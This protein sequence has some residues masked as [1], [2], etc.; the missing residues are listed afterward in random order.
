M[1]YRQ[2]GDNALYATPGRGETGAPP[3]G[4]QRQ[5]DMPAVA[6]VGAA[7]PRA[8]PAS[9]RPIERGAKDPALTKRR[10]DVTAVTRAGDPTRSPALS[11]RGAFLRYFTFEYAVG[12]SNMFSTR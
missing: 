5:A 7:A 6:V 10:E 12:L 8:G 9:A 3:Q 11:F 2:T 4:W 1:G